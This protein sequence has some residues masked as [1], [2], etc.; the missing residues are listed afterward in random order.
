MGV[1]CL[2]AVGVI[3]AR[4]PV[5]SVLFLVLSFVSTA[6]IWLLLQAEFLALV[7]VVVYVGAVMVLFLFVVMM[8][9]TDRAESEKS[10][11]RYWPLVLILSVL[12]LAL[13]AAFLFSMKV[14]A[15]VP[16]FNPDESSVLQIGL[17]LYSQYLY[18]FELAAVILLV[19][20]LAAIFLTFRPHPKNEKMQKIAEQVSVKPSDRLRLI[21][22]SSA[23]SAGETK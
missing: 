20:M 2:S 8:I 23:T 16:D 7:L 5:K 6:G 18:P 9:Q 12:F 1:S 11:V 21:E 10:W 19:A 22:L 3:S 13:L 15:P 14:G 4:N 17:A